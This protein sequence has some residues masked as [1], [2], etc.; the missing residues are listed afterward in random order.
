MDPMLYYPTQGARVYRAYLELLGRDSSLQNV[1][2]CG[3]ADFLLLLKA[4]MVR[5]QAGDSLLLTVDDLALLIHTVSSGVP[6]Q[7]TRLVKAGL[8]GY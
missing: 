4:Y 7:L 1:R 2:G 6:C 3:L 8:L 5:F